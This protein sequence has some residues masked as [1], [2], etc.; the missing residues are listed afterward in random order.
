MQSLRQLTFD[1]GTSFDCP[2]RKTVP[3]FKEC[4]KRDA[5]ISKEEIASYIDKG[6]V[7]FKIVGRGLPIEMVIDSYIYY[8]VKDEHK[9]FIR[10]KLENTL[11][12]LTGRK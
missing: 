9:D 11:A 7:N 8:L 12:K 2:N 1:K 5:F 4:M 3:A 10:T 6:F